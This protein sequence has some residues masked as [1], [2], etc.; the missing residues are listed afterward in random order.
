MA[1][2][3]KESVVYPLENL[4]V[5]VAGVWS[6]N[7]YAQLGAT[8]YIRKLLSTGRSPPIDEV[9]DSG[10]VPRFIEFLAWE[11]FPQLQYE[12]AVA[13]TN[14]SSGTSENNKVLIDHGAVP[15]FVK[16]LSSPLYELRE[17]VVYALGNIAGDSPQFRDLVLGLG[18]LM[19]LLAQ[20]NEHSKISM[21][22]NA[23]WTLSTFCRG[24]PQPLFEQIKPALPALERLIHSRDEEVLKYACWALSYLSDGTNDTVQAVI[25]AGFCPRLVELLLHPS[26]AVVFTALR[27]VGN[28]VSGDDMQTQYMINYQCLLPCL[29]NLLTSN[30]KTL[31]QTEACWTISNITAGNANQIQAVIEAGIIGPLVDLAQSAELEVKQEAAWA[32]SNATS[33]G[34]YEQIKFLVSQGCIKPLCDLLICPDPIILK[35]C[36][37]GLQNILVV[38]EAEK[39]LGST[40]ETNLY[41]QMIVD[42][43]GLEKISNLQSHDNNNIYEKAVKIFETY[44]PKKDDDEAEAEGGGSPTG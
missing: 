27:T 5:M 26:H 10:V 30:N 9:V 14:I 41:A 40:G 11:G 29:L 35:V 19:P 32:M 23:T 21:L 3:I 12:A 15:P 22:R 36:L 6:E 38:G 39:D 33:V 25:G 18:A 8:N 4:P 7:R 37:D 28:I 43:E 16:L 31:I 17:Q 13:L 42:A 44:W 34:T 20:F 2:R 1:L 24:K